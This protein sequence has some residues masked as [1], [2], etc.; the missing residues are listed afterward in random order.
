LSV[1][2]CDKAK[3]AVGVSSGGGGGGGNDGTYK[4]VTNAPTGGDA[5]RSDQDKVRIAL[6]RCRNYIMGEVPKPE[7]IAGA[8]KVCIEKKSPIPEKDPWGNAFIYVPDPSGGNG[9]K[10]YSAGPDGQP[11][12]DDDIHPAADRDNRK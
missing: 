2:A 9:F 1:A 7:D 4:H 10:L 5:A 6:N 8:R 11:D 3:E 12:T